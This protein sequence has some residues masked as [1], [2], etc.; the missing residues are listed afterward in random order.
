MTS[1]DLA[2]RPLVYLVCVPRRFS[3]TGGSPGELERNEAW[4]RPLHHKATLHWWA[5][6]MIRNARP[7]CFA[8]G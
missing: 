3:K 8:K 4:S 1:S 7:L 6:V 5:A 2:S